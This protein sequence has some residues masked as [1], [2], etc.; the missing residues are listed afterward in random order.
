MKY[1]EILINHAN[2]VHTSTCGAEIKILNIPIAE[3]SVPSLMYL[4]S[5]AKGKDKVDAQPIPAKPIAAN[6]VTLFGRREIKRYAKA[7]NSNEPAWTLLLPLISA[8]LAIG[9]AIIKQIKLKNAKQIEAK[10]A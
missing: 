6:T 8:I 10:L 4:D 1:L 9:I 5:I 7:I 2:K 3:P